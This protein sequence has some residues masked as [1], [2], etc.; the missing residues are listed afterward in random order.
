MTTAFVKSS[1]DES[2]D[3]DGNALARVLARTAQDPP[4]EAISK[5][6]PG[7]GCLERGMPP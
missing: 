2:V 6:L 5:R 4:D 1:K 7:R 3:G